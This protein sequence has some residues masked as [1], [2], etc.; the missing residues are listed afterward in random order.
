MKQNKNLLGEIAYQIALLAFLEGVKVSSEETNNLETLK[1]KFQ[2][3]WFKV[4]ILSVNKINDETI[5]ETSD[6]ILKLYFG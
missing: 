4:Q 3:I 6:E 5:S 1:K 2:E